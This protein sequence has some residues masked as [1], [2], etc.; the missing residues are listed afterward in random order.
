MTKSQFNFSIDPIGRRCFLL[1]NKM[2]IEELRRQLQL[3][4]ERAAK[5]EGSL[6]EQMAADEAVAKAERSLAEAQGFD[7]AV[8]C[9]VGCWPDAAVS[10]PVLVQTEGDTFLTFTAMKAGLDGLYEDAGTAV[11]EV[12]G[13]QITRFGYPND[14]ALPGHPLYARGLSAYGVFE[15]RNSRWV[16]ELTEQN[17][18]SF[19]STPNSDQ[20]HFIVSF[21]DST[22][23]C[24]ADALKVTVTVQPYAEV[25]ASISQRVFRESSGPC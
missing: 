2:N 15:V 1:H 4:E 25:F 12:E 14:E 7:Y 18:V 23:E 22:F 24:I 17:R 16:R 19:P 3:A 13:C 21:H 10:N 9:D 5:R 11:V 20:T 6:R 8:P